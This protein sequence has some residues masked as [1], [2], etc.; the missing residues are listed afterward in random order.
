[1]VEGEVRELDKNNI[2]VADLI[3][4]GLIKEYR[5]KKGKAKK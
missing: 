4:N 3:R 2:H 5:S 1:M